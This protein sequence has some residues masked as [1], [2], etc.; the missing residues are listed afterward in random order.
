[1]VQFPADLQVEVLRRL[2]DLEETDPN[3]L[4]EVERSLDDRLSQQVKM[5]RNRVAGMEAISGILEESSS[6]VSLKILDNLAMKDR[7][8][9][10]KFGPPPF[11]F[12]DLEDLDDD[13][14]ATAFRS[15]EPGWIMP[16]LLGAPPMLTERALRGLPYDEAEEIRSKLDNPGPIRLSD[17]E[18]ARKRIAEAA[19]RILFA[20]K[21]PRAFAA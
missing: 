15:V 16:A 9:A 5:Q 1:L 7:K 12:E 10:Q 20:R 3:I 14:L 4:R 6:A 19:R 21:Q 8:L 13:T 18:A 17:M 2:A 11:Y